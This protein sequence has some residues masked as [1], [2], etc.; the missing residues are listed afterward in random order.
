MVDFQRY[1]DY[2]MWKRTSEIKNN[3]YILKRNG[4]V[5]DKTF[6]ESSYCF[7]LNEDLTTDSYFKPDNQFPDYVAK[8]INDV[9]A[10]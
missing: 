7:I 6:R 2:V 5:F 9:I 3:I 10:K 1:Q 8:Y 4:L